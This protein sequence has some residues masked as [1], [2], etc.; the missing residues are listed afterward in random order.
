[1]TETQNA[2][3]AKLTKETRSNALWLC[4]WIEWQK[5]RRD[6]IVKKG[7]WPAF[8]LPN[9]NLFGKWLIGQIHFF[10]KFLGH[11]SF[12]RRSK[13]RLSASVLAGKDKR[14]ALN[15]PTRLEEMSAL[16]SAASVGFGWDLFGRKVAL[17]GLD[18]KSSGWLEKA[19]G[20]SR[21]DLFWNEAHE[22]S[23]RI[24]DNCIL[25]GL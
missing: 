18:E 1:M 13:I 15:W 4:C 2:C 22:R 11:S 12:R 24:L 10:R 17:I 21:C 3:F 9:Q 19:K 20:S 6:P 14:S 23:N 25:W 5:P 7:D 16:F 8:A